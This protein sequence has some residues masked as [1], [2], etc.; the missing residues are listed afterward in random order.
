MTNGKHCVCFRADSGP[1]Q[2]CE[3]ASRRDLKDRLR[4]LELTG[5]PSAIVVPHDFG[6]AVPRQSRTLQ[7]EGLDAGERA[8]MRDAAILSTA[9]TFGCASTTTSRRGA[10]RSG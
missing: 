3:A 5:G 10:R 1:L 4:A 2:Q 9:I 8:W 6:R 7:W